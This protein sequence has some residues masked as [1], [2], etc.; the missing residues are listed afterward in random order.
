KTTLNPGL[1]HQ[2]KL[3]VIA[4]AAKIMHNKL[5]NKDKIQLA[6]CSLR[7]LILANYI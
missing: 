3:R 2:K 1:Q 6:F 4:M 5:L 7:L